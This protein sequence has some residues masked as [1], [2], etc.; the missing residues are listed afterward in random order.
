VRALALGALA[1]QWPDK[2]TLVMAK[3]LVEDKDPDLALQAKT[4]TELLGRRLEA[5]SAPRAP[6]ASRK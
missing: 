1:Y 3:K 6:A 4:S 5:S 2:D